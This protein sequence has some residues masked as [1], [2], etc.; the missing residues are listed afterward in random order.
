ML[1]FT[2][3][4]NNYLPK[5]RVLAQSLKTHNPDWQFCLLLGEEPPEGFELAAW[6]FDR[7]LQFSQLGI[8]N[9]PG[10]SF[11]HS[12]VELC[13]AVKGYALN[14]FLEREARE[15]V[16]Y[17]D[18]DIM[19][20]A[21]LEPLE[22]MLD[23]ADILLTPHQLS[24]QTGYQAIIDNE[25]SSLR[26]GV[27]N[28][29][30]VGCANRPQGVAFSRFWRDRL[31]G[32]CHDD[33]ERGL[34]TD[35]KWCD[36]A[37][38]YF[39]SLEVV[40]DPGCNAASWN[41]TDRTITRSADGRFLA[42]GQPLRFYH[43]TGYDS[44][45]GRIMTSIYGSQMPAVDA[46]WQIYAQKLAQHASGKLPPWS[47]ESFSNGSPIPARARKYYRENPAIQARFPDPWLTD[48]A[49]AAG[50]AA[51][52][53]A[54]ERQESNRLLVW[55]RKPFR[56][57][58]LT[59]AYLGKHGGIKAVPMLAGKVGDIWRQDGVAGV[60]AK[61]REF[62]HKMTRPGISLAQILNPAS[63]WAA[64]FTSAFAGKKAVLILDHM[65]GGGA[66]EYREK[67]MADF[68]AAGSPVLLLLWDFFGHS[69]KCQFR[70]P[71]G[72]NVQ[73]EAGDLA[74]IAAASQLRFGHILVNELVLWSC[75][76]DNG[77]HYSALPKLIANIQQLKKGSRAFLEVA[78]HDFYCLC[79]SYYLLESGGGY[80]AAPE[81]AA[82]CRSCLAASPFNVPAS[83][84]LAAWRSAWK[85]LLAQADEI[86]TFS[87]SA[88]AI[89]ARTL[90]LPEKSITVTQHDPLAP[91]AP[92]RLPPGDAPLRIGVIGHIAPHKG[93]L[94]VRELAALLNPDESIVVIGELENNGNPP[95]NLEITGAYQRAELPALL[96]AQRVTCVLVPSI[97]P[98][99]FCYV[100]QE[101]MQMEA[102]LVVFPLGA[103][104]ERV[105]DY[106][107]G[108]V[109]G[110]IS[111]Q[112]A[113]D[114]LR[115]LH[116]RRLART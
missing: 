29:G 78:L 21:S 87:H 67:R 50:F 77:D 83:F 59:A 45:M 95:P 35:Q 7:L 23:K 89:I 113:L 101:C 54:H 90:K 109:A 33:K 112:S 105:K 20:L 19:V 42:N 10:W 34:F 75:K 13:T 52:W 82:R 106:P 37:P 81:D 49:G 51:Y 63:Q 111:A 55:A 18:P 114:A 12:V 103:Q 39:S 28:L 69:L 98:E 25:I 61:I 64:V 48:A 15:K 60:I 38:A 17:L 30:F 66:N 8:P 47:G 102:P 110:E 57:A 56:L 79:P 9:Y 73:V 93:S 46:L 6:P 107:A 80:C 40:R 100:V 62:K 65:Y 5:A 108:I 43:F 11:G 27:F 88:A 99:T 84:D 58:T 44:G 116:K 26:H 94:I 4:V 16:I 115:E 91:L 68:L 86:R 3:C 97:W 1:V 36:L 53:R 96:A 24:P 14:Y 74:E 72:G 71:D 104:A 70:L 22:A 41:L 32:W 85:T 92:A 76:D 31:A 2:S